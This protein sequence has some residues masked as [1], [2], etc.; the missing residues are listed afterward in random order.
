LEERKGGGPWRWLLLLLVPGPLLHEDFLEITA[1]VV[2]LGEVL[3]ESDEAEV[4]VLDDFFDG[5]GGIGGGLARREVDAGDLEAIEQEAGAAAV[6]LIGGEAEQDL[7]DGGLDG[8]TVFRAGKDE[9]TLADADAFLCFSF[10][11]GF[12]G[13]V[14]VV[15]ELFPLETGRAAAMAGELDVA[16]LE[17]SGCGRVRLGGFGGGAGGWIYVH[18][19]MPPTGCFVSKS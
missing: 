14:V 17:A 10:W 12:A 4:G 6:E 8:G 9:G 5:F 18:G 1:F 19:G 3:G 13:D 16:A 11:N 2:A 15:A 7:A